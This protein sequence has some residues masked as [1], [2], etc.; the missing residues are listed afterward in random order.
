MSESS[1]SKLKKRNVVPYMNS[2]L[3]LEI[4]ET[5]L[6]YMQAVVLGMFFHPQ[7]FAIIF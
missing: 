6:S 3:V 4:F 7:L 2:K 1:T 5:V